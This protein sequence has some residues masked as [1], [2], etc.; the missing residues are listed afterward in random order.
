MALKTVIKNELAKWGILSI[1]MVNAIKHDQATKRSLEDEPEYPDGTDF[2]GHAEDLKNKTQANADALKEKLGKKG[3][4]VPAD[5]PTIDEQI[6]TKAE[7]DVEAT[8]TA[9][10]EATDDLIDLRNHV[11]GSLESL[12]KKDQKNLMA[13][14]KLV[15]DMDRDELKSLEKAIEEFV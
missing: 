7:T 9:E 4:T 12:D 15:K 14:R 5:P 10:A 1:E 2:N 13:G 3:E 8:G 6:L 11:T